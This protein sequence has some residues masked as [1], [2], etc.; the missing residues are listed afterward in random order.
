M[1]L[2]GSVVV[3]FL[4]AH[5]DMTPPASQVIIENRELTT[6]LLFSN[7]LI[8][9]TPNIG[10]HF[11]ATVSGFLAAVYSRIIITGF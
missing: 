2:C 3:T 5:Q 6:S 9:Y 8:N 7:L 4:K 11:K 1:I 10:T